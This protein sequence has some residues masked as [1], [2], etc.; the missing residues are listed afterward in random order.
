[1]VLW[2]TKSLYAAMKTPQNYIDKSSNY[3]TSQQREK[4]L[5]HHFYS[6]RCYTDL[7]IRLDS[8]HIPIHKDVLI[9][10]QEDYDY[11]IALLHYLYNQ[12]DMGFEAKW[13]VTLHYQHPTE[14]AKPFKETNKPYGFGDRINF[15]TKTNI[16]YEDALYKYWDAKRKDEMQVVDDV[17]H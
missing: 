2:T 1:M 4:E 13:L 3:Q 10:K 15:K 11:H 8:K 14:H 12:I 7:S 9:C 6:M 17:K 16:W 5:E